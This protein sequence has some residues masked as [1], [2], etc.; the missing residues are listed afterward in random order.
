MFKS[1][2][3]KS[4]KPYIE[5]LT[6][7]ISVKIPIINASAKLKL[8]VTEIPASEPIRIGPGG[9]RAFP[10]IK[11]KLSLESLTYLELPVVPDVER[12][13]AKFGLILKLAEYFFFFKI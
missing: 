7:F 1:E 4:C 3:L 13:N 8:N 9:S 11:N 10:G 2:K 12:S 6:V 5:E